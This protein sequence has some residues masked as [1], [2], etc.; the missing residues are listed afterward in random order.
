[1]FVA[2]AGIKTVHVP[3]K[4]LADVFGEMIAGRVHFY[5][6]PLPAAMPMLREGKLRPIAVAASPIPIRAGSGSWI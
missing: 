3:F 1:M 6:F 4:S 5:V 2:V